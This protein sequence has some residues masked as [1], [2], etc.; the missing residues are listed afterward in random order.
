MSHVNIFGVQVEH[1][2]FVARTRIED[3]SANPIVPSNAEPTS[4]LLGELSIVS[5]S[6]RMKNYFL[7][8][9]IDQQLAL[10]TR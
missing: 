3:D 8:R 6:I 7:T 2:T 10:A 1:T 5:S 4:C 9:S